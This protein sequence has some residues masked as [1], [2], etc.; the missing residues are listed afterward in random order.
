MDPC[1]AHVLFD[2]LISRKKHKKNENRLLQYFLDLSVYIGV[3]LMFAHTVL[4]KIYRNFE[5][6]MFQW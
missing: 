4:M 2:V 3:I 5:M 1:I 6:R